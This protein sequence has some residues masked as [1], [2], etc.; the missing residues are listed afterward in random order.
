MRV[1]Q[2]RRN[3]RLNGM[4]YNSKEPAICVRDIFGEIVFV[5]LDKYNKTELNSSEVWHG[6]WM[7]KSIVHDDRFH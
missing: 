7:L 1:L 3:C 6:V 4:R 5:H 2:K